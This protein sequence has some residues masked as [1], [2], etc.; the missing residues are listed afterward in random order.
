MFE[1]SAIEQWFGELWGVLINNVHPKP[2]NLNKTEKL[3]NSNKNLLNPRNP[4]PI[5]K[6][7]LNQTNPKIPH[8]KIPFKFENNKKTNFVNLK[9]TQFISQT[10]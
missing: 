5:W 3:E 2:W 1:I 6:L 4:F 8:S 7:K 10:D 9:L